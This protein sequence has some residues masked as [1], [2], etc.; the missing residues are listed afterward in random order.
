VKNEKRPKLPRGLRWH[1]E[2]RF[3][4]FTWYDSQG[5]Q[6]KKSTETSDPE[7]ALL[8]KMRFLEQQETR[9]ADGVESADLRSA[10]LASAATL[11]FHWKLANNSPETVSRERRM[12]KNVLKFFGPQTAVRCIRLPQ[13]RAYQKD[14]RQQISPTMKQPVTARS[15]N[16]ELQLLKGVMSYAD[17]WSDTLAA[18]YQQPPPTIQTFSASGCRSRMK[19]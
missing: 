11:Y 17:C 3:I 13:I 9:E 7:K 5:R 6:H 16:Y 2:S 1:S 15:V 19:L 12:F 18:R 14:R 8:F 10:S 4:W